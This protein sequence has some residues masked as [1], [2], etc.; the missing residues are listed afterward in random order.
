M[1]REKKA[2]TILAIDD[3]KDFLWILQTLIGA[4]G[5]ELAVCTSV[6]EGLSLT[7]KLMPEVIFCDLI[8]PGALSGFDFIRKVR[9]QTSTQHLPVCALTAYSGDDLHKEISLQGF[10]GVLIK[11]VRFKDL[12]DFIHK[13]KVPNVPTSASMSN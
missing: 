13:Y 2:P 9:Q 3:N 10:N 5:Y 6:E 12:Q 7:Q 11:P 1:N 8:L 4:M